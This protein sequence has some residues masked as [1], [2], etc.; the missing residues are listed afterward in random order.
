LAAI[1]TIIFHIGMEKT[2]TDSFQR[3]CKE[4]SRV[5]LGHGVLYPVHGP[6]FAAH[7]HR[8]LVACY[9]PYRDLGMGQSRARADVLRFLRG[10]IKAAKPDI[11]LISAEHFSSRFGDAEI[12][13][14][15]RDFADYSSRIAVVVREHGSRVRSAYAQTIL[16]GRT[17]SFEDYC[18]EILHPGNRYVR[19][20][21]T[22][23][24]WDR[25]F[26]RENMHVLSVAPGT[27]V[28]D[29]LCKALIPQAAWAR[30]DISYWENK[31]L[32]ASATEALR[33]VNMA[34]PVAESQRDDLAGKL[35]WLLL[36]LARYRIR[37]LIAAATGDR[38]RDRFRM[39]DQNHVRLQEVADADRQ[40]L[41]ASY[42]LP[43]DALGT[44]REPPPDDEL[45]KSLAAQVKARP[46]VKLLMAM[47]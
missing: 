28:V 10:E 7:S 30:T 36:H 37:G 11:V 46:W 2:G 14:L 32:G 40:W 5:L 29:M 25:T 24:P 47:R 20:R 33:H 27:N 34:L 26:G 19:Y 31:S 6:A 38:P 1:P 18:N 35:K 44:D 22:I 9:L 42:N 23:T 12:A 43:L 4:N 45:A 41:A 21:D 39:S 17:L 16:A 15:A 8:P 3:F 13:Q